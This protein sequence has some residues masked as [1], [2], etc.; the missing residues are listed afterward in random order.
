MSQHTPGPWFIERA[1]KVESDFHEVPVHDYLVT[2][3]Q[4]VTVARCYQQPGDSW[5][6]QDNA[7]LIATAPHLLKLVKAAVVAF[8]AGRS[9]NGREKLVAARDTLAG[10]MAGTMP[11]R[12][13]ASEALE[14]I[15]LA[16][17]AV[18]AIVEDA[19][20]V[21]T[22]RRVDER[23]RASHLYLP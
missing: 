16:L 6:A 8:G 5:L 15:G 23:N 10:T 3:E 4:G 19:E 11:L 2:D 14:L 13:S 17:E 12:E 7:H 18:D 21:I 22:K 9:D 1:E 20:A